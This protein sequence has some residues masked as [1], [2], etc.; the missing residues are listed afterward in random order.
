MVTP[1]RSAPTLNS[2]FPWSTCRFLFRILVAMVVV[3]S[4]LSAT[5]DSPGAVENPD[6]REVLQQIEKINLTAEQVQPFQKLLRQYY[7]KRNGATR[8]IARQGG[9]IPV[10]VRRDVRRVARLSVKAMTEVLTPEQIIQY[11][12]LMEICNRQ[13]L[14]SA[15]LL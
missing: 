14:V 5:E 3:V 15:G 6:Q 9:N 13:Y 12:K 4:P 2:T 11:E 7:G 1:T 10:K 8:R